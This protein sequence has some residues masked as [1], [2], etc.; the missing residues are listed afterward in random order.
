M[1]APKELGRRSA[2][3]VAQMATDMHKRF[4]ENWKTCRQNAL[5]KGIDLKALRISETVLCNPFQQ[6]ESSLRSLVIGYSYND[7][8]W[9]DITILV[10]ETVRK[11]YISGMPNPT[12]AFRMNAENNGRELANARAYKQLE[13]KNTMQQLQ[14]LSAQIMEYVRTG[15]GEKLAPLLVYR[16]NDAARRWQDSCSFANAEDKDYIEPFIQSNAA[17][18]QQCKTMTFGKLRSDRESEGIWFVLPVTCGNRQKIFAF[19][20]VKGAFR[21]GD[22]DNE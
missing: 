7:V 11:T 20:Y 18:A 1:A 14:Q 10:I 16:G 3:Q 4:E 13:D 21:L 9:D 22:V 6:G 19:L 12:H 5:E 17:L 15:N 8:V 2:K